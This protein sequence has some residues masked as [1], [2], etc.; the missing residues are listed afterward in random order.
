[1]AQ[2]D[3]EVADEYQV[4]GSLPAADFKARM[5][6][7]GEEQGFVDFK[8]I[9]DAWPDAHQNTEVL[10]EVFTDLIQ[11][12]VE[13]AGQSETDS[14]E[15][16]EMTETELAH[17]SAQLQESIND[18]VALYLRD[19]GK[20]DLLTAAE[21]V[22][23][24]KRI[25]KMER[26][27]AKLADPELKLTED[28]KDDLQFEIIDGKDAVDHLISANCR[29]VV[30][31][32]KKYTNRGVPFLD[33]VQEGNSGLIRAVSKFDYHRGFKFSTYATW[34]IRQAV[35]RA[36]ADQGRT[37]R[38]PV[39]MHEQINRLIRARHTLAQ[40]F[41]RE[42]TI[43]ELAEELEIPPNKVEHVIR[44][45]QQPRSLEQPVGE[46]EDSVLGDFIP[47]EDADSPP[48]LTNQQMLREVIEDVI[49]DLTPR[50]IHTLQLRFGM[51]DDYA[52]TLE[53]VGKK[54]GITRERVRQIET[55]ALNRLRHS[56]RKKSLN[57][58]T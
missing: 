46:E 30:S 4:A 18:S 35:T 52:Y 55:Q 5:L 58:F 38:V 2:F 20:T 8:D 37:I 29:L 31:V 40:Q 13:I 25:E 41:G 50:E 10:Q 12:G 56:S 45:N 23:L 48:D 53:E 51:V 43:D 3:V 28:E 7:L 19:I 14:L 36:I 54:F 22:Q 16:E 33:L 42:P 57:W 49:Q 6:A 9:L 21:E 44:V 32:A 47:D 26:A 24:A 34:W 17:H 39:H 1:M 27:E 15:E 11:Q